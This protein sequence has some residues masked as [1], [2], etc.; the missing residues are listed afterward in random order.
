MFCVNCGTALNEGVKFC[1]ECGKEVK[2]RAAQQRQPSEYAQPKPPLR[3]YAA[4]NA[5]GVYYQQA[6]QKRRGGWLLP[7]RIISSVL[8]AALIITGSYGIFTRDGGSVFG[9]ISGDNKAND[10]EKTVVRGNS[11]AFEI[12]PAEGLKISAEE[13]ALDKDRIWTVREPSGDEFNKAL[14]ALENGAADML[15]AAAYEIDA[16]LGDNEKF[17]GSFQMEFDLSLMDIPAAAYEDLRVYRVGGNGSVMELPSKLTGKK[18]V[19]DSRQNSLIVVGAIAAGILLGKDFADEKKWEGFPRNVEAGREEM[20]A[21]LGVEIRET[22]DEGAKLRF[23]VY[24]SAANAP[25]FQ[26]QIKTMLDEYKPIK[27]AADKKYGNPGKWNFIDRRLKDNYIIGE[28]YI[29]PL[30][31]EAKRTLLDKDWVYDNCTTDAAKN[32]I[33]AVKAAMMYLDIDEMI[34]APF[35]VTDIIIKPNLGNL[36]SSVNPFESPPYIE[37]DEDHA[38]TERDNLFLTVAHEMLHVYQTSYTV[39]EWDADSTFWEMTAIYFESKCRDDYYRDQIIRSRPDLTETDWHEMLVT[40]MDDMPTYGKTSDD[41]NMNAV[42]HGYVL[43]RFLLYLKNRKSMQ[44]TTSELLDSYRDTRKPVAAVCGALNLTEKEFEDLYL[45]FIKHES[46]DIYERSNGG[47][48]EPYAEMKVQTV[49]LSKDGSASVQAVG[50][51]YS[52]YAREIKLADYT[53]PIKFDIPAGLRIGVNGTWLGPDY[54]EVLITPYSDE[55]PFI[56]IEVPT[57]KNA[58]SLRYTVKQEPKPNVNVTVEIKVIKNERT[59]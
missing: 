23:C 59:R 3:E 32:T 54:R 4:Q 55:D 44:F 21:M 27:A 49:N 41:R 8:A 2:P 40:P 16:G 46:D 15:I 58:S 13:N 33:N 31:Y 51:A 37:I 42:R 22:D 47:K 30:Y 6:K 18:L 11:K 17:P 12:T 24:W 19:C 29:N 20:F 26:E 1:T 5:G 48:A 39:V 25:A 7:Y 56:V 36:G 45:G 57:V 50:G 53:R 38:G 9:G 52:A 35:T 14:D 34:Y 43:G 28:L 10:I